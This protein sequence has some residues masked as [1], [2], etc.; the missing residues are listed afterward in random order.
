L[1]EPAE[2]GNVV[3][4]VGNEDVEISQPTDFMVCFLIYFLKFGLNFCKYQVLVF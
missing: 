3:K 4:M 1:E 2:E